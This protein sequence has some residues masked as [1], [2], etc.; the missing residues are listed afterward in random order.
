MAL[1]ISSITILA[2]GRQWVSNGNFQFSFDYRANTVGEVLQNVLNVLSTPLGSQ[3]LLRAFGMDQHW[4][5]Q[6]GSVGQFQAR[7]A[8]LLS[9]GLWE[10]R[11]RVIAC[12][13]ILETENVLA[14]GYNLFLEIEVNITSTVET[15][16]FSAPPAA[17]IYVLDAPFAADGSTLPYVQSETLSI[18]TG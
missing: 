12:D 10:P 13:F 14:G 9:I 1:R 8:A 5:D 3:I 17:P 6:P 7:T 15:Q 16:V 2:Q 4:V 18:F 11:A